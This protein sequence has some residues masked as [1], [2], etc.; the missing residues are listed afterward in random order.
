MIVAV[1]KKNEKEIVPYLH[2]MGYRD[3]FKLDRI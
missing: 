2:Q 1:N 3:L